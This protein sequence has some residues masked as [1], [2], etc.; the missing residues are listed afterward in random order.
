[1]SI[2]SVVLWIWAGLVLVVS[3]WTSGTFGPVLFLVA[4][5]GALIATKRPENPISWL[6][7][8]TATGWML[9]PIGETLP[10][11]A[12]GDPS[13]W[14][15][16]SLVWQNALVVATMF[17]PLLLLFHVFPNGRFLNRRWAAAGWIGAV[18]TPVLLIVTIFC[19]ELGPPFVD[20]AARW[21]VRNPIGFIPPSVLDALTSVWITIVVVI[22]LSGIAALVIRYRRSPHLVRTQIKWLALPGV[23]FVI[24]FLLILTGVGADSDVFGLLVA[25]PLLLIPL[26]MTVA[27]IRYRLFE[28]DR[29]ISRTIGYAVVAIVVALAYAV[30]VL[31]LPRLLGESNDLAVATATLAAAAVFNPA[32]RRIQRTVDRRFNRARFD[33]ERQLDLFAVGI[34]SETDLTSI[35]DRL[36]GVVATTLAP[37]KASLWIR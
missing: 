10:A 20:E 4:A 16:T 37:E 7:L 19:R 17:Y 14:L 1:M 11:T 13:F 34:R 6:F 22:G 32:R 33:A 27:I 31:L 3:V 9:A 2:R 18:M 15:F 25:A 21:A 30:P 29:I 12:P 26:S 28:I 35:R 24:S 8:V 23:T 5:L 36:H